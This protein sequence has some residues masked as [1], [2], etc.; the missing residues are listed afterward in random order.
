MVARNSS[1]ATSSSVRRAGR[2]DRLSTNGSLRSTPYWFVGGTFRLI[3]GAGSHG[4]AIRGFIG[5]GCT[6]VGAETTPHHVD[7]WK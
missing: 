3:E 4:H 2:P 5:Q 1:A 6:A 7:D